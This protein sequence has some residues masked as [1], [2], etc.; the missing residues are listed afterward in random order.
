MHIF[1]AWAIIAD[2]VDD[3]A[4]KKRLRTSEASEVLFNEQIFNYGHTK[5]Q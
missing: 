1:S 4:E 3:R 5:L 2:E